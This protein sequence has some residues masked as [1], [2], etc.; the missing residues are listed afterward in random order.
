MHMYSVFV[1]FGNGYKIIVS[2]MITFHNPYYARIVPL[3]LPWCCSLQGQ[4]CLR[5]F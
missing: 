4:N 5:R 1:R 3:C 2:D